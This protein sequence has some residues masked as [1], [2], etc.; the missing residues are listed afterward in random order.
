MGH[1]I[2]EK[3]DSQGYRILWGITFSGSSDSLGHQNIWA[4]DSLEHQILWDIRFFGTLGFL[5]HQNLW[6][7]RFSGTSESQGH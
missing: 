5:G 4:S 7:V 3:S 6:D 2:S 1:Q